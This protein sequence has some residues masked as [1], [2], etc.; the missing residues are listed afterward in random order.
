M[1]IFKRLNTLFLVTVMIMTVLTL[2]ASVE[3]RDAGRGSL[4]LSAILSGVA[5]VPM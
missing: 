4:S 1:K 5:P 3:V 2:L